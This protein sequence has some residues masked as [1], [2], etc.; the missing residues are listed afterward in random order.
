MDGQ[1]RLAALVVGLAFVIGITTLLMTS[2][3]FNYTPVGS[4]DSLSRDI[5]PE[6][7]RSSREYRPRSRTSGNSPTMSP[8]STSVTQLQQVRL[9]L[10]KKDRELD[11]YRKQIQSLNAALSSP[12]RPIDTP[13]LNR[14]PAAQIRTVS[15]SSTDTSSGEDLEDQVDRLNELLLEADIDEAEFR[16]RIATLEASLETATDRLEILQEGVDSEI[17]SSELQQRRREQAMADLVIKT[18]TDTIPLL[19]QMLDNSDSR[20]RSWSADILGDFGVE[21]D[22]AIDALRDLTED[23]STEVRNAARR[24][25][26]SIQGR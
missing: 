16:E 15:Q 20:V 14:T 10:E 18:G 1:I 25:L 19:V 17:D 23:D 9:L 13:N 11:A 24:A 2:D 21:A 7:D 22:E 8:S 26:D 3:L 6:N 12:P 5:L 4:L